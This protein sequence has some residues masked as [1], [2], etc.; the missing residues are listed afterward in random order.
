MPHGFGRDIL[1][2]LVTNPCRIIDQNIEPTA[3]FTYRVNGFGDALSGR[4]IL[5]NGECMA[6]SGDDCFDGA[7]D[8]FVPQVIDANDRT[9][10]G[11]G[12]RGC[13]AD[14]RAGTRDE[15]ITPSQVLLHRGSFSAL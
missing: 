6:A 4:D 10:S 13:F 8:Q 1:H 14:S 7:R 12:E 9:A 11:K 5:H 2:G 15:G 3:F